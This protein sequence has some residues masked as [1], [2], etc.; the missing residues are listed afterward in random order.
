MGRA[1]H[2]ARMRVDRFVLT[3]CNPLNH[4]GLQGL[5]FSWEPVQTSVAA[6]ENYQKY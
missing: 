5:N 6:L 2:R 1:T 4:K 3:V